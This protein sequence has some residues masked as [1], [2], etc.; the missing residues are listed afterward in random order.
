MRFC[1]RPSTLKDLENIEGFPAA[2]INTIGLRFI[3]TIVEFLS[4]TSKEGVENLVSIND[5]ETITDL[6]QKKTKSRELPSWM[7]RHSSNHDIKNASQI[8]QIANDG[9]KKTINK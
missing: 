4:N 2:K 8:A 3:E 5:D 9:S 6:K 7:K 1:L